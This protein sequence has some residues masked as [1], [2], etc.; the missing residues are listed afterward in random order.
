VF[1]E[2]FRRIIMS[3]S[4]LISSKLFNWDPSAEGHRYCDKE[5]QRE[6][7]RMWCHAEKILL[8]S[9][10]TSYELI[11]CILTLRRSIDHRFKL[12]N[13][14]Y[15]FKK[16]PIKSKPKELHEQ[17]AYFGITRTFMLNRIIE[18]R[19]SVEHRL[20]TPPQKDRCLEILDIVW[21][22]LKSTDRYVNLRL[23]SFL[24]ECNEKELLERDYVVT[25][26]LNP[27]NDWSIRIYGWLPEKY[28]IKNEEGLGI[29]IDVKKFETKTDALERIKKITEDTSHIEN[30]SPM[31]FWLDGILLN[32]PEN[33]KKSLFMMYFSL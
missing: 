22:F 20:K 26:A 8:K 24:L 9:T 5:E 6:A 28:L 12:L 32:C 16:I 4:I 7:H 23:E 25:M 10:N 29:E 14:I 13:R 15:E 2:S 27:R 3:S 33:I 11:D 31:D 1:P 21:Y 30:K 18:I 19:N 17:L